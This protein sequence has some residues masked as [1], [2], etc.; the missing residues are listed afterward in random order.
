MF[1]K[2]PMFIYHFVYFKVTEP[3]RK[4]IFLDAQLENK[5]RVLT[6]LRHLMFT[7]F[8]FI[9]LIPKPTD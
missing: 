9:F 3:E 1:F 4:D 6:A 2:Q 7:S 5:M 8:S